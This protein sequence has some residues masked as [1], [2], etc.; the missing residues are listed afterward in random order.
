MKLTG[1]VAGGK[2][3]PDL[4]AAWPIAMREYEGKDVTVE[5]APKHAHRSLNANSRYWKVDVF[6]AMHYL[7]LK[8]PGLLPLNKD[9]IHALL[10]TAFAGSEET[11]LGLAPVATRTMDKKQFHAFTEQVEL[12][13]REKGYPIPEGPE[14]SVEAAI[15]E[16]MA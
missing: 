12:F 15:Q 5:I 4:P 16:A 13:L 1:K 9:Q 8:R 14:M 6:L 2:F 10:V 3:T 11:E 7:N